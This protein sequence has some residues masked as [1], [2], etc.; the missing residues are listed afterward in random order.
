MLKDID[1]VIFDLDGTLV[2]SMW[3]WETIDIEYLAKFGLSFPTD[4]QGKIE[5]MSFSETARYFKE[6]F[7]IPDSLEKIKSDWNKMARDKYQHEVP[8]KEGVSEFLDY[9]RENKIPAGIATS[10]S[11]ELVDLIIDK[12][13]IGDYF[14]SVRTSC[15][16][17]KGKPAPDIYLLVAEDLD[18]EPS[19]CLAFEDII[20]GIMAAKNA[21][22]K[23]CAV[24]DKFSE[25]D[26]KK[27]KSLADY[28]I[29]SFYEILP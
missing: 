22:M 25:N 19:R 29:R 9:L 28:Y 15:E 10:N 26:E 6:K 17:E 8:L 20:Q 13:N 14:V 16:V 1:A 12:H 3:M 2:D 4:L 21:N 27:K 5:G 7:N 24:H 11:R 18:V 23:V